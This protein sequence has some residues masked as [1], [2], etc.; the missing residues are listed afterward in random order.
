MVVIF[1]LRLFHALLVRL[2]VTFSHQWLSM[3]FADHWLVQFSI[4][5]SMNFL[6]ISFRFQDEYYW[7]FGAQTAVNGIP[8][9]GVHFFI[10]LSHKL[11]YTY[12]HTYVC[13]YA[14]VY[15][16]VFIVSIAPIMFLVMYLCDFFLH[17]CVLRIM[18]SSNI[19]CQHDCHCV[20]KY[21]P[22]SYN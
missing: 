5:N 13:M 9:T 6:Q 17:I 2:S 20:V 4:S 10:T 8:V 16:N 18:S 19:F 12:I 1:S 22:E 7:T 3:A 21:I 14:F 15:L 11:P